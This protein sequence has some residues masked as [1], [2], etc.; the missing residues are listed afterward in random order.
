MNEQP[1]LDTTLSR[2]MAY[3]D[4]EVPKSQI[5][6]KRSDL[7]SDAVFEAE[8]LLAMEPSQAIRQRMDS[9]R[10]SVRVALRG[11]LEAWADLLHASS[12]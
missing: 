4:S 8:A 9:A 2:L 1:R 12:G 6:T 5:A 3:L 11:W 10:D 7:L